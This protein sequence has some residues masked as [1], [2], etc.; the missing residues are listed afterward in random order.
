M[1]STD[2]FTENQVRGGINEFNV[3]SDMDIM[4]T[5]YAKVSA[6]VKSLKP[7]KSPGLGRHK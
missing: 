5:T 1:N 4:P 7:K 3:N 6:I 2:H